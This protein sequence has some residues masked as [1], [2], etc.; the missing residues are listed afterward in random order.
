MRRQIPSTT[1]VRP[2][3]HSGLVFTP[4][5]GSWAGAAAVG[6]LA[7]DPNGSAAA[8][9][10]ADAGAAAGA[11]AGGGWVVGGDK[12]PLITGGTTVVV[13]VV[14]GL[15]VVVVGGVV[16]V[17]VGGVQSVMVCWN[18]RLGSHGGPPMYASAW[19][20]PQKFFG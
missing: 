2:T 17:V 20:T 4:V 8:G 1:S 18:P 13:V 7:G 11:G 15:V 10:G 12:F 9:A 19:I 16:V 14:V 6:V 5:K 3:I